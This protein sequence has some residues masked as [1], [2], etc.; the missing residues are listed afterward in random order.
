MALSIDWLTKIITVPKADTTLLQLNPIE[1]RELDLDAFRLELKSIEDSDE[2]M[3][4]LDTH[5]HNTTVDIGGVTLARVIEIINGYTVTFEDGAYRVNLA[6][7]NSNVADV[8]NLNTVQVASNNS[9]GL[10]QTREIEHA[11]FNDG[12]T[13]DVANGVAGTTYPIGTQIEPVNNLD[14]ALLIA[15]VRGFDMIRL[16]GSLMIAATDTIIGMKILG[17]SRTLSVLTID[18]GATI[19][20]LDVHECTVSGVFG[21]GSTMED[22][23]VASLSVFDGLLLRCFLETTVTLG[24]SAAARFVDCYSAV[25]GASTPIL[26]MGGSG[27]SLLMRNYTGGIEIQN[28]TGTDPVSIDMHSGHVIVDSTVTAGTI[29]LRGV[30]K[31]TD[32]S[33]PGATVDADNLINAESMLNAATQ[34]IQ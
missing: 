26:D 8:L 11:S 33:G 19:T 21:G 29:I 7:A 24:N 27:Q 12:V 1:I 17:Q 14:D 34:G 20:D 10:I 13:I 28:R 5:R 15:A 6:G 30:G 31:L 25:P 9:A 18:A 3:P 16:V 22:C 2:G 23:A 4:F 32:N